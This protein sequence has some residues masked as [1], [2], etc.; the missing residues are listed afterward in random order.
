MK[1]SRFTE[2][3]IIATYLWTNP[4]ALVTIYIAAALLLVV[5]LVS[6]SY[7]GV[8]T[9]T[10]GILTAVLFLALNAAFVMVRSRTTA[11]GRKVVGQN[12]FFGSLWVC[13]HG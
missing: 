6:L 4:S 2:E 9:F 3:Q 8:R 11:Q 12:S 1:R 13:S 10:I 5:G 7:S